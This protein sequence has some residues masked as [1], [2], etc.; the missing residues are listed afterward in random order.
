M[1]PGDVLVTADSGIAGNLR[2]L[3]PHARCVSTRH[4]AFRP[5]DARRARRYVLVWQAVADER[6]CSWADRLR[7]MV[8]GHIRP[9]GE[10]RFVQAEAILPDRPPLRLAYVRMTADDALARARPPGLP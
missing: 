9:G 6:K 2:H 7:P 1:T 5:R 10:V 8:K 3:L 4:A